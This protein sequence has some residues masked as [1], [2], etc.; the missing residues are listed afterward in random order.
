MLGREQLGRSISEETNSLLPGVVQESNE[1]IYGVHGQLCSRK[2]EHRH[3][4]YSHRDIEGGDV[5]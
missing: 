4:C 5:D 2:Q 3:R 1:D